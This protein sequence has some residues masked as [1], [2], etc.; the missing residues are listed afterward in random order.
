MDYR[1]PFLEK[2][3]IGIV[4]TVQYSCNMTIWIVSVLDKAVDHNK[5]Q[6]IQY[7]TVQYSTVHTVQY[8]QYGTTN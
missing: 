7:S 2:D 3:P 4:Q 1:V 5:I 6:Y 8:I